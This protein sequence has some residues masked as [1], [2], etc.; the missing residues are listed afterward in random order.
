MGDVEHGGGDRAIGD[1]APSHRLG[2]KLMGRHHIA[3]VGG[4]HGD[5]VGRHHRLG[6]GKRLVGRV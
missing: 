2:M 6:S 5:G 4:G 3:V 1:G